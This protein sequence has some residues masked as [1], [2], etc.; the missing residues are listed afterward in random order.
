MQ[1]ARRLH[2]FTFDAFDPP[3]FLDLPWSQLT[4]LSLGC[5]ILVNDCLEVLRHCTQLANCT[6]DDITV[7]PL[8]SPS[9][10]LATVTRLSSLKVRS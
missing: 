6:F 2:S 7:N 5:E 3:F 9:A 8:L 10:Q 1:S 4:L